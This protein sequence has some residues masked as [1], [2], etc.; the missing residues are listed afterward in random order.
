M[1]ND[2]DRDPDQHLETQAPEQLDVPPADV[3]GENPEEFQDMSEVQMEDFLEEAIE[4]FAEEQGIRQLN[5]VSFHRAGLLTSD[6][7]IVV[8]LGENE[9]QIRILRT[10]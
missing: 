10:D 7:G 8:R 2:G 4:M 3:D 6:N 1:S 9:Y 5:I